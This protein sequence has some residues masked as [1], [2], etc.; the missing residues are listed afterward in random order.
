MKG[1]FVLH[2]T[3]QRKKNTVYVYY[4]I[5]WYYRKDGKPFRDVI[6]HLGRLTE[7]EIEHYKNS[8]AC[9]NNENYVFPCNIKKISV[10]NSKDF[11]SCSVGAHFWDYWNLSSV[12]KTNTDKKNVST[13]DIAK[14]LTILRFVQPC[15]KSLTTELY[16]DTCLPEITKVSHSLYNKARVFRELEII[17]SY[18]NVLG[19]HIFNFA[20]NNG[21]TKG[22]LL[23]YDLSSGNICGLKCLLAKWGH[24]KD[25]YRT[26]VVLMLVITPE[27][28][29][30]YWEVLEGNTAD[31]N[32]IKSLVCKIEKVYGKV[33]SV[34]CFDR[35]MVSDENLKLLEGKTIRFITALDGNQ[36]QHFE[37]VVNFELIEKA[38]TFDLK[39]ES[40][41]IKKCLTKEKFIFAK[42]NLFYQ[43][44]K[45]SKKQKKDIEKSTSKLNLEKRRYFLSFNP[46]LA[47]LKQK[48][49]KQ[50]V[51]EFLNWIEEY[52]KELAKAIG[53]RK[54]ESIEKSIKK[55]LKK[56]RIS[57]VDI[58]YNLSKYKVEN[59]NKEGKI[60]EASTY[61][62]IIEKISDESYSVARKY[63][64]LWVLLTN[65]NK[66]N[67]KEFLRKTDFDSF[68]EIYR[69]KNRIEESFR[70]ISDFV[71]IEPFYVYKPEHVKAHF[72]ICVLSYLLDITIL[73]KIRKNKGFD[74]MSLHSLFREL[75]KCKQ[76]KIQL[77][78]KKTISKITQL[79][80]TQKKILNVLE[81]YYLVSPKHLIANQ[82]I[83]I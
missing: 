38:K 14:I 80:E 17:E 71:E 12:F 54:N 9:L 59:K 68:F 6:K 33:E 34:V 22:E 2:H 24:C 66:K 82:I 41:K 67:E 52:N 16:N 83:S 32:T 74:N 47:Y 18:K 53:S 40:E 51:N 5:A 50:R 1:K 57:D 35:G 60:K 56:Q 26:H 48:H 63:D 73:N 19:R 7:Y 61:K 77:N 11:L 39:K 62:I 58:K 31:V 49:R 65:I 43:E 36:I 3:K 20:K 13:A 10:Q 64:G 30:I 55:E 4:M 46:E 27:G 70:I 76:D 45:L 29:P 72:T 8:V 15:S 23:F 81:C 44:I 42:K 75:R 28:F 79:T 21:L 37:E 78:E 25:G 69:L